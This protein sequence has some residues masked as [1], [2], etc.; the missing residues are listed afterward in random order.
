M[1][2]LEAR[3][4]GRAIV[5]TTNGIRVSF[6]RTNGRR[7]LH[8]MVSA[9]A[10]VTGTAYSDTIYTQTDWHQHRQ[11]TATRRRERAESPWSGL[12][13]FIASQEV[14]SA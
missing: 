6:G 7:C 14:P 5:S 9:E 10:S 2:E 1:T 12:N 4:L 8:L 3:K 13:D 11:N